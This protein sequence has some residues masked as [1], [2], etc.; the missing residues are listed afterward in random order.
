MIFP[1]REVE[2]RILCTFEFQEIFHDRFHPWSELLAQKEGHVL[3][4][5]L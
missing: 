2:A 1:L 4:E 5:Q 3:V